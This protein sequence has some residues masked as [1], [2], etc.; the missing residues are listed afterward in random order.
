MRFG[1]LALTVSG[2]L[3]AALP[4]AAWA[5]AQGQ[6]PTLAAARSSGVLRVGTTGDYPPFSYRDPGS[7][8]FIGSDIEQAQRLA[9]A[10][11]LRLELVPTSWGHLLADQAAGRF[12]IAMGGVSINP[13]R[14]RQG[15]FS[16][17]YLTDGKTPIARCTEQARYQSLRQI[18]QPAVRVIVNPGGTNERF[19]RAHL[20]AATLTVFADNTGVFQELVAG[21][22]DVMITDAIE[23]RLQQ[24]LHP[25]LCA[26]H[27][28]HP[29]DRSHKAYLLP[30]DAAFKHAVDAW[31][32]D[33]LRTGRA[34][35]T[36]AHWLAYDWPQGDAAAAA[37]VL[38]R[39][40]DERLALMPDVA[41]YKWNQHA[42]IE[43]LP[44][45]Q[46]LIE[47]V[48]R[49]A[50]QHGVEPD[51]AA[52]FFAAQIEASKVIQRELFAGWQAQGQGPFEA[53]RDLGKDIRPRLD[54]LNPLLLAA[55]AQVP[56]L[57]ERRSFG[58]MPAESISPAAVQL[59]LAPLLK[60]DAP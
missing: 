16:V 37:L 20:K 52:A 22:A 18:D 48:R 28:Q 14:A 54:A 25:V 2:V 57:R 43:D 8:Q 3:L 13:E 1:L 58:A 7:G 15:F 29:F 49:Q 11:R 46:A 59:A 4:L 17:P 56:E 32:R 30:R 26:L 19:A 33:Q 34:Q 44:R 36:L 5:D 31:L 24:Q 47:S 23:A 35:K 6:P 41:R 40:V 60:A 51:R 38:G 9:D 39:L 12:D 10:L 50:P 53:V 27:P 42:A 45:E 55:L 21:R